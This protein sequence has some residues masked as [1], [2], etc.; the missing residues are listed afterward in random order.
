MA[1]IASHTVSATSSSVSPTSTVRAAPQ[2]GVLEGSDP[3]QYNASNPI[4]LFIIQV[5]VSRLLDNLYH[6]CVHNKVR[7]NPAFAGWYHYYLLPPAAL[8]SL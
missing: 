6:L 7:S 1:T 3:S 4:I 8:P 5:S 2:G